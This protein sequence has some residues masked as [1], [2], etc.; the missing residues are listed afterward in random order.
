MRSG[1]VGPA[2]WTRDRPRYALIG[3]AVSAADHVLT[4]SAW[5]TE[6]LARHGI[7]ATY[8]PW[9]SPPVPPGFR[10]RPEPSPRFVYLGRLA[11]EKG[12]DVLLGAFATVVADRSGGTAAHR[13]ERPT[14]AAFEGR[15]ESS[16]SRVGRRVRRSGGSC[17]GRRRA[18]RRMGARGAL[19][20]GRAVRDHRARGARARR[21]RRRHRGRRIRRDSQRAVDGD[22]RAG[23]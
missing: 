8:L 18:R 14:R 16:R 15:G 5:M 21:S 4:C 13:R 19:A 3:R 11:P 6:Q 7:A 20:L 2:H 12:V 17:A 23:R 1:C 9:P 22:P 10:P